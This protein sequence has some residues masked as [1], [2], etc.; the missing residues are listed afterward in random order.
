MKMHARAAKNLADKSSL[1]IISFIRRQFVQIG[2]FLFSKENPK[3]AQL[4]CLLP[5]RVIIN[6]CNNM[7]ISRLIVNVEAIIVS[8]SSV[9]SFFIDSSSKAFLKLLAIVFLSETALKLS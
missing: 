7:T 8:Q 5:F 2:P 9:T 4:H 6:N 1:Q 3:D